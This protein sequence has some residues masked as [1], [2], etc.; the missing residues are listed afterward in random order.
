M[1]KVFKYWGSKESARALWKNQEA[2]DKY[3]DRLWHLMM[4]DPNARMYEGE[5]PEDAAK[6]ATIFNEAVKRG[7][8]T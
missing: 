8:V 3:L 5:T 2:L 1:G 4:A 7:L 6:R